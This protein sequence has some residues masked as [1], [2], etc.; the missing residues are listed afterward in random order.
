[1]QPYI[2]VVTLAVDD[3]DRA[4]RFYRAVLDA[5][6]DGIVATEFAGDGENAAGAVAMFHLEGGLA[7]A[8]YPRS[9]LAKDARVPM[10]PP[11]TGEFSLAQL[12]ANKETVD[13]ALAR[14]EAA[15]ATVTD[16]AHERPL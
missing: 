2:N 1:M 16:R 9:E 14:A 12:V 13:A 5:K 8:L 3:L 7:L 11:K 6:S 4:L 10:S 15:G